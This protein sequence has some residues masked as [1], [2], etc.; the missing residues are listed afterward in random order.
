MTL[1]ELEKKANEINEEIQKLKEKRINLPK[2]FADSYKIDSEMCVILYGSAVFSSESNF[3]FSSKKL[4][5]IVRDVIEPI[6]LLWKINYEIYGEVWIPRKEEDYSIIDDS[7]SFVCSLVRTNINDGFFK[8]QV[9][10]KTQKDAEKA[11]LKLKNLLY[12]NNK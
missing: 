2:S 4:A 10:F 12:K 8:S 3:L 5:L 1:E 7:Y 9:P 6:I 11:L